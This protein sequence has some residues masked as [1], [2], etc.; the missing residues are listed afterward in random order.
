[1]SLLIPQQVYKFLKQVQGFMNNMRAS[2][3][4]WSMGSR[5]N[6]WLT[7][8]AKKQ[9][10]FLSMCFPKVICSNVR[11]MWSVSTMSD[12]QASGWFLLADSRLGILPRIVWNKFN[13]VVCNRWNVEFKMLQQTL[14]NCL[15]T[16]KP[17]HQRVNSPDTFFKFSWYFQAVNY[18]RIWF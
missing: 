16:C 14:S 6:E 13:M 15:H 1:M 4:I 7:S 18:C 3:N 17:K 10:C 8:P 12:S 11:R 5:V 2:W 9:Q